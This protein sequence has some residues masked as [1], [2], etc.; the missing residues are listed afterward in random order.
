MKKLFKFVVAA[1]LCM[2]AI[3]CSNEPVDSPPQQQPVVEQ[4]PSIEELLI[5]KWVSDE[6]NDFDMYIELRLDEDGEGRSKQEDPDDRGD[7]TILNIEWE[8]KEGR[9]DD[10]LYITEFLEDYDGEEYEEEWELIID[11]I[12][13]NELV[14]ILELDVDY[15]FEFIRK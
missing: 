6:D 4:E 7:Y 5:G 3:S 12:S 2:A 8:Y 13:E 10:I 15:E 1:L 14:L 11:S 9:K